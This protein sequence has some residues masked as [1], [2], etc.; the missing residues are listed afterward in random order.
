MPTKTIE[1]YSLIYDD[2]D[3]VG[4]TLDDLK[5]VPRD[6]GEKDEAGQPVK[7]VLDT[8]EKVD[9]FFMARGNWETIKI[10]W[11]F[12]GGDNKKIIQASLDW[13]DV[14]QRHAINQAVMNL[15]TVEV[16]VESWTLNETKDNEQEAMLPKDRAISIALMRQAWLH[17]IEGMENI[18]YRLLD[19]IQQEITIL[20]YGVRSL[21]VF[22]KPSSPK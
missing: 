4:Y 7:T 12:T 21:E 15:M 10:R 16:M 1:I 11:P 20:C 5:R 19:R 6:A 2:Y 13:D 8:K 3:A 9:A 14:Q 18:P 22:T 17:T